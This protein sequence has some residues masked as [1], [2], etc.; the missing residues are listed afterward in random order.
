MGRSIPKRSGHDKTSLLFAVKDE[1]GILYKMLRPFA[2]AGINLTKIESRPMVKW[3][4]SGGWEYIFFLDIEGHISTP[5]VSRAVRQLE[6]NCH[7]LKVL[8]SYPR[9]R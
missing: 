5:P 3:R 9:A 4:P 8:G 1:I 6:K 7:F 2:E